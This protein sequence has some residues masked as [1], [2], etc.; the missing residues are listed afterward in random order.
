MHRNKES[1]SLHAKDTF[2]LLTNQ[3]VCDI[4]KTHSHAHMDIH[5]RTRLGTQSPEP[6]FTPHTSAQRQ[7]VSYMAHVLCGVCGEIQERKG[8]RKQE[9]TASSG[10]AECGKL[11]ACVHMW[12]YI[13]IHMRTHAALHKYT[14]TCLNVL[15][16]FIS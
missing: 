6:R 4:K 5:I 10:A 15:I 7:R 12:P 11:P 14:C 9:E 2:M 1:F 13:S 8:R 3:L 16:I